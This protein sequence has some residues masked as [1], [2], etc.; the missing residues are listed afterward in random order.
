MP[1]LRIVWLINTRDRLWKRNPDGTGKNGRT[2]PRVAGQG[3]LKAAVIDAH[4]QARKVLEQAQVVNVSGGGI[5]F[6][7]TDACEIGEQV[8]ISTVNDTHGKPFSVRIVGAN[9][10]G[11]GRSELRGQLVEGSVPACLMYGW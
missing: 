1:I 8:H 7:S 6:T 5:A 9:R 10:R 3:E 2:T 11:D 4:G